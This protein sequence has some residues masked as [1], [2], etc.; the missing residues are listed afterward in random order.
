MPAPERR[1]A[2][3]RLLHDHVARF[4]QL[5]DQL[6]GDDLR[7]PLRGAADQLTLA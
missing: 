6:L 2:H 1:D 5:L 7:H 4:R 3:G